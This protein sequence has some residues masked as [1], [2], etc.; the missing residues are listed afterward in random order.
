MTQP[1]A[2]SLWLRALDEEFGVKIPIPSP[3]A[4]RSLEKALYDARTASGDPR[5]QTLSLVKPGGDPPEYWLIKK[6]TDMTDIAN[7]PST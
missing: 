4:R 3:E 5:L 7:A 1:E 6:T 2:L